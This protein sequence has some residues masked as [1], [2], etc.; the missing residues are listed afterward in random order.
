MIIF[1]FVI[2][3]D[4]GENKIGY[5]TIFTEKL[6][7]IKTAWLIGIFELENIQSLPHVCQT[8]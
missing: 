7:A 3:I 8:F 5:E 2:E 4:S 1:T 6:L